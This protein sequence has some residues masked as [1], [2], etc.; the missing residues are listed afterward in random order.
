MVA[1]AVASQI[2]VAV[3]VTAI[4]VVAE[5]IE[6]VEVV[7]VVEHTSAH[8]VMKAVPYVDL[9]VAHCPLASLVVE[10]LAMMNQLAS[11]WM[12]V[13]WADQLELANLE[14]KPP[15]PSRFQLRL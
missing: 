11:A 3:V 2:P 14:L 13:E 12:G 5:L 7:E 15:L 10:G 8:V 1:Q 4:A 6:V 9:L